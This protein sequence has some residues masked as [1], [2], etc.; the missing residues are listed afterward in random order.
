M[1]QG[2]WLLI[3]RLP[4]GTCR[5][6]IYDDVGDIRQLFG[7]EKTEALQMSDH[8]KRVH[9]KPVDPAQPLVDLILPTLRQI[10]AGQ[11]P[12][13]PPLTPFAIFQ[14]G[15]Q[16]LSAQLAGGAVPAASGKVS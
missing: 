12:T 7:A 1:A 11:T 4:N 13:S 15:T 16:I 5:V 10:Q 9:D 3:H 8:G 6:W 2:F 14:A